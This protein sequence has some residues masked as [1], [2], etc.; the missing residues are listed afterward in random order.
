[1]KQYWLTHRQPTRDLTNYRSTTQYRHRDPFTLSWRQPMK[2][3]LADKAIQNTLRTTGALTLTFASLFLLAACATTPKPLSIDDARK[4]VAAVERAFANSMADRDLQAFS[5]FI[6]HDAIF[7]G[8]QQTLR[9]KE[10]VLAAWSR[11]FEGQSAPFSWEPDQVEVLAS[12]ALAHSSG[13]VRNASG[14]LI[15]RF[16]SIW[17]LEA[18]DV[19]RIV[20]DRGENIGR[21]SDE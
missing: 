14:T 1:M 5:A 11:Y 17:R 6:A 15:G 16:N 3:A 13:P 2:A 12:G 8:S 18:P 21:R 10:Q 4:Q 20:F 19:W 9:G 7:F